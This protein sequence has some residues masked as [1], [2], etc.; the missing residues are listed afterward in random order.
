MKSIKLFL[1]LQ[2]VSWCSHTNSLLFCS[3]QMRY[4]SCEKF[5]H[6]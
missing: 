2:T 4:P 6:I 1:N 3:E 5:L